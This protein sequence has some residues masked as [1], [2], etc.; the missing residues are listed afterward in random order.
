MACGNPKPSLKRSHGGG[1]PPCKTS[2]SSSSSIPPPRVRF[3]PP[4][5]AR[6]RKKVKFA[7]SVGKDD[8]CRKHNT[9][10]LQPVRTQ[11]QIDGAKTS[12]FKYFKKLLEGANY[13]VSSHDSFSKATKERDESHNAMI[14]ESGIRSFSL[15][16]QNCPPITDGVSGSCEGSA[17]THTAL[18]KS[19]S[20]R[21]LSPILKVTPQAQQSSFLLLES[22]RSYGRVYEHGGVF[23]EKRNKLMK[24]AAKTLSLEKDEFLLRSDI[25]SDFMERLHIKKKSDSK[26][27]SRQHSLAV[28]SKSDPLMRLHYFESTDI[29]SMTSR[30][31]SRKD[32]PSKEA[33]ELIALPWEHDKIWASNSRAVEPSCLQHHRRSNWVVDDP[34]TSELHTKNK[35]ELSH[36]LV[37]Y[38]NSTSLELRDLRTPVE[39]FNS[40]LVE[41]DD[42]LRE[43]NTLLNNNLPL[44]IYNGSRF[45]NLT[46][47]CGNLNDYNSGNVFDSPINSCGVILRDRDQQKKYELFSSSAYGYELQ[48]NDMPF[49]AMEFYSPIPMNIQ[50][51]DPKLRNRTG[52]MF[53]ADGH[54]GCADERSLVLVP[55]NSS[56]GVSSFN[57]YWFLDPKFSLEGLER[58]S[59]LS[60]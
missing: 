51:Y 3:D 16:T 23:S 37:P 29:E 55:E 52:S 25:T 33:G 49:L 38:S 53:T 36:L 57:N 34:E 4:S 15:P 28:S 27:C 6:Q 7:D 20:S 59:T 14:D 41:W 22:A 9:T 44:T 40:R 2:T 19:D 13:K 24:L 10:F 11:S 5:E 12:E 47:K 46:S 39:K 30:K 35:T 56:Y 31:S 1:A 48:K 50:F 54:D 60:D 42:N 43:N 45:P 32:L 17:L 58:I 21:C 8:I 18:C 26:A